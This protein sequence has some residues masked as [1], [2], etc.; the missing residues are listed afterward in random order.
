[1]FAIAGIVLL[2]V[3]ASERPHALFWALQPV[4]VT[5]CLFALALFGLA[6][7]VRLRKSQLTMAPA[8]PW[9]LALG[10]CLVAQPDAHV[11][12]LPF[13]LLFMIAEGVQRFRALAVVAAAIVALA[14]VDAVAAVVAASRSAGAVAASRGGDEL[15]LTLATSVPLTLVLAARGRGAVRGFLLLLALALA[16]GCVIVTRSPVGHVALAVALGVYA[17]ARRRSRALGAVVAV[18]LVAAL[19]SSR[20]GA[21]LRAAAPGVAVAD[22]GWPG[23]V[24]VTALFYVSLKTAAWVLRRYAGDPDAAVARDWAAGLLAALAA[25]AVGAFVVPV[26][27]GVVFFVYLGLAG[28]LYQAARA[29]DPALELGFAAR[30]SLR[31]AAVAAAVAS[32]VEWLRA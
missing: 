2:L 10:V 19:V 29:H 25:L 23:V 20:A 4:P 1:M 15:A 24:L 16:A 22:G 11:V 18:A 32:V 7:D 8:L 12:A 6:V 13:A 31:L 5:A 14:S 26:A 3:R 28:A 21:A 9:A 30:D 27:G 17:A